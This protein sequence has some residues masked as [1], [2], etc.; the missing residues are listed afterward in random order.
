[1]NTVYFKTTGLNGA[2]LV[3]NFRFGFF[4]CLHVFMYV[5]VFHHESIAVCMYCILSLDILIKH[6]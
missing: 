3:L 4:V 6:D 5:N 2:K 1:M